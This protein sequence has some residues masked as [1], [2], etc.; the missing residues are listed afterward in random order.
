MNILQGY[1]YLQ[2]EKYHNFYMELCEGGDLLG[3]LR[4]RRS[5]EEPLAKQI[6][7]QIMLGLRYLHGKNMMHRDLRLQ[8]C[9][10]D[11]NGVVKI[12]GFNFSRLVGVRVKDKVGLVENM[13][14]EMHNNK[15]YGKEIDI[16]A[17]GI[18]LYSLVYGRSPFDNKEGLTRMV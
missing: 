11:A 13:A 5:L 10:I 17:A 14:P 6:F 12:A 15:A 2:S 18:L 4:R 16:W 3:Y 7:R 8:N 1:E 9:L